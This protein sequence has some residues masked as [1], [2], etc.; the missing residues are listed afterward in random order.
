MNA[1]FSLMKPSLHTP[2]FIEMRGITKIY[3]NRIPALIDVDFD[4]KPCEVHCVVGEN[5]AGKSTLMKILAGVLKPTKGEVLVNGKH[6]AFSSPTDAQ[7]YGIGMVHQLFNLVENLTV[8]DN[9]LLLLPLSL[10]EKLWI[11][12]RRFAIDFKQFSERIGLPMDPF[13]KVGSLSAGLKQ[14]LEILRLLYLGFR[15][16]I[17]DEP[18]SMLTP[19]EAEELYRFVRNAKSSGISII[20]VTHRLN[21]VNSICDRVTVLRK[22][23]VVKHLAEE[24]MQRGIELAELAYYMVGENGLEHL[25]KVGH[26]DSKLQSNKPILRIENA[27]IK[28]EHNGIKIKNINLE[29][30]RGEILGIAGVSGN[31]QKELVEGLLGYRPLEKG[32]ITFDGVDVTFMGVSERLKMGIAYIPAERL[33][34][35]VA[36]DLSIVENMY[37]YWINAIDSFRK[38]HLL[39]KKLLY[40]TA[41]NLIKEYDIR[42]ADPNFPVKTLSGG[43]IQKL[44]LARIFQNPYIKVVIAEEPTA[45]LDV[46]TTRFVH[47]KIIE[48][49]RQGVS[50]IVFSS[51]LDELLNLSDRLAVM[52]DGRI[53]RIYDCVDTININELS[54][55]MMGL[56][57]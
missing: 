8:V 47:R 23:K 33:E 28:D 5:G 18:T 21:E 41:V 36:E 44:I 2:L 52:Y 24:D 31:G 48:A 13:A 42:T 22:G 56:D 45:G 39:K 46:K 29:L 7:R 30:Y 4:V 55:Y 15:V 26:R 27:V 53:T 32:K 34:R 20:W 40:N 10:R 19:I 1:I 25:H 37:T 11:N 3:L 14:R 12:R 43:N 57:G 49:S 38:Q 54:R 6:V 9:V 50:F 51:E 17:F 16:L 35:G